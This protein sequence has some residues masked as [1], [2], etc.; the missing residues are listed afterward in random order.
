MKTFL[1]GLIHMQKIAAP[2][3]RS[4]LG[5]SG[6]CYRFHPTCSA[7]GHDA[8]SAH[9]AI[10]GTALT[11]WRIARCHPWAEG[12]YDPVPPAATSIPRTTDAPD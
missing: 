5:G 8:L 2:V 3:W 10:R 1:I 6:P 4:L 7:Y 11:I 9:G 12:G